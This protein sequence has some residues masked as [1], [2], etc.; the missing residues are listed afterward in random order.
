MER[1]VSNRFTYPLPFGYLSR[2]V[3]MSTAVDPDQNL[4]NAASSFED[5]RDTIA[6]TLIEELYRTKK[7]SPIRNLTLPFVDMSIT[8]VSYLLSDIIR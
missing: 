7:V 8:P 3:K 4:A 5:M 6:F 2:F 1:G